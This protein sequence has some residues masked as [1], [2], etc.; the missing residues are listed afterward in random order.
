M[1]R[2]SRNAAYLVSAHPCLDAYLRVRCFCLVGNAPFEFPFPSCRSGSDTQAFGFYIL[3]GGI[4]F[5]FF[6]SGYH[7]AKIQC[8]LKPRKGKTYFLFAYPFL[9]IVL[10]T[11]VFV[12][13]L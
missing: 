7:A 6:L 3:S 12:C 9:E 11:D 4:P 13:F 2:N 8:F 5:V 10:N 1:N